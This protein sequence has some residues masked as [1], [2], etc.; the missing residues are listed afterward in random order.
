MHVNCSGA[1][2]GAEMFRGA[3]RLRGAEQ[4]RCFHCIE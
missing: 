4:K 3:L 1:V 2:L